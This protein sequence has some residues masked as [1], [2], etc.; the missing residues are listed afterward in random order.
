[1]SLDFKYFISRMIK[2]YFS[3]PITLRHSCCLMVTEYEGKEFK[4]NRLL[5]NL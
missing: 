3:L 5:Y 4:Q 2:E 1:M